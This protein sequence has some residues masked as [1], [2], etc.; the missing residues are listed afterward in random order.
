[1]PALPKSVSTAWDDRK[2]PAVFTTVAKDGT[3]T[4]PRRSGHIV[5]QP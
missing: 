1:M 5:M 2:G 4:W 3:L